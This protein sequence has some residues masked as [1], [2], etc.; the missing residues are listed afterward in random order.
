MA[1]RLFQTYKQALMTTKANCPDLTSDDI[2]VVLV[3]VADHD[4]DST[5][6]GD[7]FLSDIPAGA[8]IAV[9]ANLASKAVANA[10]FD[11]ADTPLPDTGGDVAEELVIYYHTGTEATSRLLAIIDTA[12]GLP[13]TPDSVEDLIRWNAS[14]IFA[15]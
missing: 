1:N 4:P 11:A 10:V 2:R 14:G 12:P 7:E 15:L 6:G 8:R 3:D 13:I 5:I 9:T